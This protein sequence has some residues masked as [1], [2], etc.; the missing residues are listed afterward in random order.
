MVGQPLGS[1]LLVLTVTSSGEGPFRSRRWQLLLAAAGAAV[2]LYL[3]L[4]VS[5]VPA[6]AARP[7]LGIDAMAFL[8]HSWLL[9]AGQVA[10]RDFSAAWGPVAQLLA[11]VGTAIGPGDPLDSGPMVLFVLR[12]AGVLTLAAWVG[13]LPLSRPGWT[14]APLL[15]FALTLQPASYAVF[16][17]GAGLLALRAAA[18]ALAAPAG[19]VGS[20][21][22]LAAAAMFGALLCSFDVFVYAGAAVGIGAMLLIARGASS[23]RAALVRRGAA[24]AL[25][26]AVLLGVATAVAAL[27]AVDGAQSVWAP[28][29]R[30]VE[31]AATFGQVFGLPIQMGAGGIALWLVLVA[32]GAVAA[33][34]ACGRSSDP[35]RIDVALLLPFGLL[36][37]KSAVTRA[38]PGHVAFGLTPLLALLALLS[39]GAPLRRGERPALLALLVLAVVVW[40]T[41]VLAHAL[42]AVES[43]NPQRSFRALTARRTDPSLLPRELLSAAAEGT[44]PLFVFPSQIAFA[45]AV[46]R[47]LAAPVDQVYGAHTPAMQRR[48]VD[49]LDALGPQLGVLYALDGRPV[50]RVDGVESIARSPVVAEYLLSRFEPVTGQLLDGGY[51]LL[52]RRAS[53]RTLVWRAV[54]FRTVQED[55]RTIVETAALE[56]CPLLRVELAWTYPKAVRFGWAGGVLVSAED[57]DSAA[58]RTRLVPLAL[59]EPFT[60]LLSPLEGAGFAA[61]LG[62]G[63][64]P[65]APPLQRLVLEPEAAGPF[66]VEPRRVEVRRLACLAR[67]AAPA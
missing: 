52:R 28:W 16:R 64:L 27:T 2:G 24:I 7:R 10:Y 37:L 58:W 25:A 1:A 22:A 51:L 59:D 54:P 36:A 47:P 60:T 31:R 41:G 67:G 44:G 56:R 8:G 12:C 46:G 15:A 26:T 35:V 40:P 32:A 49:R 45:A 62:D 6:A 39:A 53:E 50:W 48:L 29:V 66:G 21:A 14:I 42:P 5:P 13:A 65:A 33:W 9:E 20:R 38:D 43:A 11:R 19:T 55:G 23:D 4:I 3:A 17:V 63:E 18:A 34:R 57:G 30:V 61:L